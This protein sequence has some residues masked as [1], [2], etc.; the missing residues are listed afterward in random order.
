[1]L[2]SVIVPV[3]NDASGLR[4]TLLSLPIDAGLEVLVIDGGS[5]QDTLNVVDNNT[6]LISHFES[7]QDTGIA[8]AMNRGV[9]QSKGDYVAILNAGDAWLPHTFD[10]V[11]DAIHR[12][13]QTDMFHGTLR[14]EREDGGTYERKPR[15]DRISRRMWMFHPTW[16]V[17]KCCYDKVGPYNEKYLLAM[18][19]EWCHRAIRAGVNILEIDAC[20]AV[21]TL[22]GRSDVHFKQALMEYRRS[23]VSHGLSSPAHAAF[24]YHTIS[25][26]KM[27]RGLLGRHG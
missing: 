7:G 8:N 16:F 4:R 5:E 10:H 27:M 19:S 13:P 20:L 12:S 3:K 23:V 2:I 15:P 17:A 21:M 14:Y 1:M 22:G 9:D 24:W 18:D 25:L 11:V 6:S 26:A